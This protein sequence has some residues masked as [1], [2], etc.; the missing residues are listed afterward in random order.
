MIHKQKIR[1]RGL[2]P[3]SYQPA[4]AAKMA[5]GPSRAGGMLR[6]VGYVKVL[7]GVFMSGNNAK[8]IISV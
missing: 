1:W 6:G 5:A 3:V 7:D 2:F 4:L 8:R